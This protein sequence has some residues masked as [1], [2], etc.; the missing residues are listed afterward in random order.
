MIGGRTTPAA[1]SA[2][3]AARTESGLTCLSPGSGRV[4][5]ERA[6][7]AAFDS[8]QGTRLWSSPHSG[9]VTG[10]ADAAGVLVLGGPRS[11]SGTDLRTGRTAWTR[12][13]PHGAATVRGSAG[14]LVLLTAP[15][16]TGGITL[17][18]LTAGG[19]TPDGIRPSPDSPATRRSCSRTR[20]YWSDTEPH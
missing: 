4:S 7:T 10:S 8:V 5:D 2:T 12:Q 16:A 14:K 19:G 6:D 18:A 3:T 1:G 20:P 17:Q 9:P 13:S 11:A 15:T